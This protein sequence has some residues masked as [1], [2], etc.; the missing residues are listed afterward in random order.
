MKNEFDDD[1]EYSFNN[2]EIYYFD[3]EGNRELIGIVKSVDNESDQLDIEFSSHGKSLYKNL[4]MPLDISDAIKV[5]KLN[6]KTNDFI[7]MDSLLFEVEENSKNGLGNVLLGA[8]PK[9]ILL[10]N[11]IS[12]KQSLLNCYLNE[13]LEKRNVSFNAIELFRDGIETKGRHVFVKTS[14]LLEQKNMLYMEYEALMVLKKNG[15][16]VPDIELKV[17]DDQ[18]FLIMSRFD[19]AADFEVSSSGYNHYARTDSGI[20][21]GSQLFTVSELVGNNSN[22]S[23]KS[24]FEDKMVDKSYLIALSF[25]N[26]LYESKDEST[27]DY[28]DIVNKNKKKEIFKVLSFNLLIGNNDMHGENIGFL[29]N[30]KRNQLNGHVDYQL[31]PFYDITP[32]RLYTSE[33]SEFGNN[34]NGIELKDLANTQYRGLLENPDFIESFKEAK[35]M[36]ADYKVALGKR[37]ENKS[38]QL[39]EIKKHFSNSY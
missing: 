9:E 5:F 4:R 22:A 20:Y 17:I 7:D 27:R 2:K 1:F 12:D 11:V 24:N 23:A 8:L 6:K 14:S 13:S 28:L 25:L 16:N 31:A 19:K 36:L 30:S 29:L 26:K 15:I 38:E 32:H 21:S 33:K 10:S 37:F 18:P 34:P 39:N 3:K 35:L